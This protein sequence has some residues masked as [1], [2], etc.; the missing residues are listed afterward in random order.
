MDNQIT[1]MTINDLLG[2]QYFIPYYQRGYRWTEHHVEDLLEDIFSFSKAQNINE[3]DFYCLQPIVVKNINLDS[4]GASQSYEIVDG[5]QRLTTIYI[6]LQYLMREFLK[7]DSLEEEYSKEIYT[8]QYETRIKSHDFLKE[9]KDD[10]SNIDF[11][12]ISQAYKTVKEWFENDKKQLNRKDKNDFLDTL[13]GRKDDNK[14]VQVIWYTADKDLDSVELFNRLNMGK[15]PLTNAELIK[16]IFLSSS[17]FKDDFLEVANRKKIVISQLWDIIEQQLNDDDFWS[18]IT[19]IRKEKYDTKIE[20][21]FD[22]ISKKQKSDIDPLFTFL[23]FIKDSKK[24]NYSLWDLWLTVEKYYYTLLE[25]YKSKNLYHKIGYLIAINK[26]LNEL[27]ELSVTVNKSYFEEQLNSMISDS[28]EKDIDSLNYNQSGDYKKIERILM[29]FNIEA[30][31]TNEKITEFY[32]FKFHK[33]Q[34]WSLEHIHAQNSEF[35]DKNKREQWLKWLD[36]H[37]KLI[38]DI[39]DDTPEENEKSDLQKLLNEVESLSDDKITWE[40]FEKLAQNVIRKFSEENQDIN[41]DSH[42]ISNLALL[43]HNENA[44]LSNS[45]FEV[46]RREIINL[47]KIGSYIPVCTKR[48]FLK[49]YDKK[50]TSQQYYFWGQNDREAYLEEIKKVLLPYIN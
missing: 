30:I 6:I 48:V 35:L 4:T 24:E 3:K 45:V 22:I 38:K 34:K 16:A 37:K 36:Y 15:I 44:V 11:F 9:I 13:L 43:G 40:I 2:K 26:D 19:N 25:W 18:F 8:I 12:H 7:V 29:L 21:L 32:P 46:K 23:Y 5:Q 14:S 33:N 41:T 50:N 17:S 20:L 1:L 28:L 10:K 31:R 39:L 27:V 49:Y 47:D 42:N